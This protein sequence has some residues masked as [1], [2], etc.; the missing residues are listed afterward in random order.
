[1]K[2]TQDP[3]LYVHPCHT[4]RRARGNQR[5]VD[6]ARAAKRNAGQGKKKDD[7]L[8]PLQRKERCVGPLRM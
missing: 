4:I 7:G 5:E 8:T 6:R 3:Q 1:M 2:A